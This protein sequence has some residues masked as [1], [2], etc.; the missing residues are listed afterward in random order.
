MATPPTPSQG[1]SGKLIL[2]L[3]AWGLALLIYDLPIIDVF[4]SYA[5]A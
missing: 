4:A 3:S 2:I 5:I 1:S